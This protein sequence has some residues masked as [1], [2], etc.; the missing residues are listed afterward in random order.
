MKKIA[1]LLLT[2]ISFAQSVTKSI[3]LLPDTGQ[4]TS[5]TN[6][7]GEDHD[8]SINAPSFT[9]NGNGTITDNVTKLMW[10]QTDGGEM[11]VE[12]ATLYCDNLVLG[13]FSDWRLPTPMEAMSILNLQKN[14][15]AM[16]VVYFPST[17]AE[18][19]WTN[20]FQVGD[21][22]KVWCTNSG[23]GIGNKPKAET[24]GAGGT[25]SYHVRAI[26]DITTPTILPNHFTD[27]GNGTIIDNV[28]QLVWQKMPNA[29]LFNWEQAITYAEGLTLASATDWRLPNIKELQSLNMESTSSPSVNTAFFS[30]IGVH[31]YWSSTTLLPNP[32]NLTT[33]WYWN[34][35]FGITTFETKTNSNY[36]ICVRGNPVSLSNPEVAQEFNTIKLFSNPFTTKLQLT[37]TIGNEFY[38]LSDTNGKQIYSGKNID[39]QDFSDLANGL[40]LLKI[41]NET[42]YT[43][44]LIKE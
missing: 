21:I 17:G 8:Y 24:I 16:D 40:Y 6:T 34:T 20:T 44:K 32:N 22:S 10:Q 23:G 11:T 19:W 42:T 13:G 1:F 7:F 33:A 18:Y 14:N 41:T 15:P 3:L 38:E 36:V 26:R 30:T 29:N 43:L 31:N 12:N 4:T 37:N 25:K 27:N 5:Y 2:T 39:T 9:N 28:T 35:Q